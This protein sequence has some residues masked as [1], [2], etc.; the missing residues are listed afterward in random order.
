MTHQFLKIASKQTR[1]QLYTMR[2]TTRAGA[3]TAEARRALDD[4]LAAGG[5]KASKA[6]RD[7]LRTAAQAVQ[8]GRDARRA[9]WTSAY[10]IR[11]TRAGHTRPVLL[12]A[13]TPA[14]RLQAKRVATM[15][16]NLGG[17][18]TGRHDPAIVISTG[19]ACQYI[20]REGGEWGKRFYMSWHV[21]ELVIT[22]ETWRNLHAYPMLRRPDYLPTIDLQTV[23]RIAGVAVFAAQWLRQGRGNYWHVESGFIALHVGTSEVAH[24]ATIAEGMAV[25][26]KRAAAK[27]RELAHIERIT[28]I[29]AQGL[30]VWLFNAPGMLLQ[31][32]LTRADSYRAGN[33]KAGTD[34][35]LQRAGITDDRV[36]LL[37]V[38]R[39][40]CRVPSHH[41]DRVIMAALAGV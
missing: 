29:N 38:V 28:A 41:A 30:P 35:W 26:R 27:A 2:Q 37:D 9:R 20:D 24:G 25:L 10:A 22:P 23:R 39:A 14:E 15:R 16:R 8:A 34:A 4:L 32:T 5:I 21:R 6:S 17:L 19:T 11:A 33:C 40:A 36:P 7:A 31:K 1:E 13:G 12:P 3:A 18:A